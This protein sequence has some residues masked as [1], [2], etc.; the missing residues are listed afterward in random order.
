MISQHWEEVVSKEMAER[1]DWW[2]VLHLTG[3]HA[4]KDLD[5]EPELM[6]VK[7]S[8]AK[9]LCPG[10][11]VDTLDVSTLSTLVFLTIVLNCIVNN[12]RYIHFFL[13]DFYFGTLSAS[14]DLC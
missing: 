14:V 2:P 6:K 8:L 10:M 1:K 3:F 4:H 5:E 11:L 9:I 13:I 7:A 12:V